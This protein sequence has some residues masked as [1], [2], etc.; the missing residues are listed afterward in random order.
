VSSHPTQSAGDPGADIIRALDAAAVPYTLHA[1][2]PAGTVEALEAIAARL[3]F[4]RDAWLKTVAFR[5]KEGPWVLVSLRAHARVDYRALAAALG[6]KRQALVTP[7][8]GEVAAA[9]GFPA[10]GVSPVPIHSAVRRV[11]DASILSLER[12]YCGSGR[13]D[14]TLEIALADLLRLAAPIVAPIAQEPRGGSLESEA[15]L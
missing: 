3:P 1:H 9:L 13:P 4:P 10:G 8:A 7:A 11:F 5:V 14:Q 6:V 12:V 15:R 2:E